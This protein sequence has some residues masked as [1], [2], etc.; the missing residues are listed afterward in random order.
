M[1]PFSLCLSRW[2][3]PCIGYQD[4]YVDERTWP[5]SRTSSTRTW[6]SWSGREPTNVKK[7]SHKYRKGIFGRDERFSSIPP[8]GWAE[9]NVRFQPGPWFQKGT[10]SVNR[11]ENRLFSWISSKSGSCNTLSYFVAA[12]TLIRD[13]LLANY[14]IPFTTRAPPGSRGFFLVSSRLHLVGRIFRFSFVL[15]TRGVRACVAVQRDNRYIVEFLSYAIRLNYLSEESF[16]QEIW[17]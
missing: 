3:F 11:F 10:I 16:V 2:K 15:Y 1:G 6:D 13:R 9:I 5:S 8:R 4:V 14:D 7:V 17:N 12:I